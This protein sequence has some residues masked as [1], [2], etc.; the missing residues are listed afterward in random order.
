M[1]RNKHMLKKTTETVYTFD[2]EDILDKFLGD[3]P[4]T[5]W[6][7]EVNDSQR[8]VITIIKEEVF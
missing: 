5:H 8:V 4:Y 2:A 7:C 3:M 6:K 1:A